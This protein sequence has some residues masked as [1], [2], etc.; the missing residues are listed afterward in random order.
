MHARNKKSH[1]DRTTIERIFSKVLER[2]MT[3]EER[4]ILLVIPLK[5]RE[6]EMAGQCSS[7]SEAD[8]RK[9]TAAS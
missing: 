5:T 7:I 2:E 6:V 9:R 1:K 3:L 8:W 4:R